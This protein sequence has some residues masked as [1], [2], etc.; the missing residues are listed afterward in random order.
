MVHADRDGSC[1]WSRPP[2]EPELVPPISNHS[3]KRFCTINWCRLPLDDDR[4]WLMRADACHE[5]EGMCQ[6]SDLDR[7]TIHHTV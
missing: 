1:P 3:W 2:G 6:G 7:S 4:P 5:R